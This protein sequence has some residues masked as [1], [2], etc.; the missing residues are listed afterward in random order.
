MYPSEQEKDKNQA[1]AEKVRDGET[2]QGRADQ[3]GYAAVILH[4]P[5]RVNTDLEEKR[6][7]TADQ[8]L[9][10]AK[11]VFTDENRVELIIRPDTKPPK[12]E[13]TTDSAKKADKV[14]ELPDRKSVV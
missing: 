1:I 7:I 12:P 10:V 9:A 4:D 13:E 14:V 5:N 2:V 6:A 11:K 8:V 3:L